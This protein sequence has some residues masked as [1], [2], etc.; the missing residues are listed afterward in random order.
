MTVRVHLPF[1]RDDAVLLEAG[2]ILAKPCPCA[3]IELSQISVTS[4]AK[5]DYDF[6]SQAGDRIRKRAA[7]AK[8]TT[9]RAFF[10]STKLFY[11]EPLGCGEDGQCYAGGDCACALLG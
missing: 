6:R 3:S 9:A 11:L 7:P 4:I 1:G 8:R 2:K 10:S 5:N